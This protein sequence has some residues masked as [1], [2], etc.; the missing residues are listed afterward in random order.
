VIDVPQEGETVAYER[1]FTVEE[2]EQF[3]APSGDNQPR[4]TE[5]DEDGRLMVQSLLTATMPTK[6]GGDPEVL[7][8]E[9]TFEFRQPVYTGERITCWARHSVSASTILRTFA[10]SSPATA[11]SPH[12]TSNPRISRATASAR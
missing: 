6:P 5:P 12:Q 3:A 1:T 7:A 2:D 9:M 4:H 8:R 10:A 11:G